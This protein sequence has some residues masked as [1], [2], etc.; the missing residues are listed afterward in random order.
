MNTDELGADLGLLQISDSFFP[1]GLYSMSS[2]LET[3]FEL[4]ITSTPQQVEELVRMQ[5][6]QQIG[7]CDCV[8]ATNAHRLA[9]THDIDAIVKLDAT[10]M[11]IKA[12][13]ESRDASARSGAQALRAACEISKDKLLVEYSTMIRNNVAAGS[14]PVSLG[15]ICCALGISESRTALSLLYG[16]SVSVIG[17]AL[18]LGI[19]QHLE[20][21]SIIKSLGSDII[22]AAQ[23]SSS[24][25]ISDMWQ[26]S[27]HLDICQMIHE[28]AE[29]R[30]FVT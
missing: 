18:R 20:G 19:I 16:F 13:S 6:R 5:I 2:G 29:T 30:M 1:V 8:A 27:P 11:A 12:S 17:A 4:E 3:L 10:V 7:P 28:R 26:F 14:Y 21:Q 22:S 23:Q 24:A 25:Q 15:I 9:Q